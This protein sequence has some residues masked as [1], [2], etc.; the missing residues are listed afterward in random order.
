MMATH[1]RRAQA[2]GRWMKLIDSDIL[3][4]HM[5]HRGIT[6]ARLATY[7]GCSRQFIHQLTTGQRS[8]CTPALAAA[9]EEVLNVPHGAIFAPK[10]SHETVPSAPS[11][12]TKAAA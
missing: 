6:K 5:K 10:K 9:I 8:S 3:I 2:K 4:A 7:V 12:R 11:S 1:R